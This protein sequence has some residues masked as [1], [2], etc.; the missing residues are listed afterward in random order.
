MWEKAQI[1]WIRSDEGQKWKNYLT[2]WALGGRRCREGQ[3]GGGGQG[4][5]QGGEGGRGQ[6][7][8]R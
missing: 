2:L 5:V 6:G 1:K 8:G 7:G 3:G 4:G